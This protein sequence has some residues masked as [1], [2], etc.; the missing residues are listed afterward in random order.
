MEGKLYCG[1]TLEWNYNKRWVDISM[2]GYLQRVLAK[3]KHEK[4]PKPQHLPYVI[5]PKKYGKDAHDPIPQDKSPIATAAKIKHVQGVIGSIL[6]YARSV[7]Q[8]FLV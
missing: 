1:I 8:T 2:P 4:P 3:Y 5:A 7:D 6:Y